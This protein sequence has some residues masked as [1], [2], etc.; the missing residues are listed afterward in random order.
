[1]SDSPDSPS[2]RTLAILD[3]LDAGMPPREVA[4]KH[5]VSRQWV[6]VIRKRAGI[7]IRPRPPREPKP[8]SPKP[9]RPIPLR[10]QA[11]IADIQSGML[12]R[13]VAARHNVSRHHVWRL[14]K[15]H[16][17]SRSI[18]NPDWRKDDGV[19]TPRNPETV[20]IVRDLRAG[21]TYPKVAARYEKPIKAIYNLV[22]YYR[23]RR[24]GETD[25]EVTMSPPRRANGGPYW[26][27]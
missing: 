16:G 25:D 23:I 20:A 17:V 10:T 22:A 11:I 24:E 1:M 7:P 18:G 8:T 9:S 5:G 13:E 26:L 6:H 21:H 3:D 2:A 15:Q 4:V 27:R 19:P 14:A 12:Y